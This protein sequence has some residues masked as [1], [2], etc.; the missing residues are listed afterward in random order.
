MSS[1]CRNIEE[2]KKGQAIGFEP[3]PRAFAATVPTSWLYLPKFVFANIAKI[4]NV[5]SP[6]FLKVLKQKDALFL[7]LRSLIYSN[8][9]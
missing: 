2:Y 4:F 1:D 5:F 6:S 9:D 3:I 7:R 8:R